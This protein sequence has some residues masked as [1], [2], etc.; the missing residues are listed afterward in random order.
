MSQS[1]H[2]TA[3]LHDL[4]DGRLE[5][6]ARV[7]V[8]GHVRECA[9]CRR[10]WEAI[11]A[12]KQA[13]AR[14]PQ[15]AMPLGFDATIAAALDAAESSEK[16]ATALGVGD[17]PGQTT[18]NTAAE[19]IRSVRLVNAASATSRSSWARWVTPVGVAATIILVATLFWWT[20]SANLPRGAAAA[21]ADYTAG[22]LEMASVESD[23]A[24]LNRYFAERVSFPV[25]VFDLGM[26][27]YTL[28]GGRVHTV[29]SHESALWVYRGSSGSLICQ[30]YTGSTTELPAAPETRTANGFT[31]LV[32]HEGG[33]TQVFWQEGTVVCV[34][35]STLPS[36]DVIQLAIAKAMKP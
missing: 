20:R 31:F 24:R 16:S 2:P 27:G 11:I 35:A 29:G 9:G 26:M 17:P 5:R 1:V 36:E 4:A 15:V 23:A 12:V 21:V 33:G 8:E 32:Y 25:R 22:Q 3:E 7:R 6:D 18:A 13:V 34:L 19:G 28:V 14:L 10:N 30:M